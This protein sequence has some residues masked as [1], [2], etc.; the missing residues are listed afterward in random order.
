[1]WGCRSSAKRQPLPEG[2]KRLEDMKAYVRQEVARAFRV[3]AL[4]GQTLTRDNTAALTAEVLR[5]TFDVF[6]S[7]IQ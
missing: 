3:R 6:E 4:S 2:I 5:D 1:M 7:Y